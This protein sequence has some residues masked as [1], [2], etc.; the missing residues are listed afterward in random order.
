MGKSLR[1]VFAVLI[2]SVFCSAFTA[3]ADEL[4]SLL[5]QA[6]LLFYASV[7]QQEQIVPAIALFQKIGARDSS[8]LGRAQTYIGALTALRAK[9]ALWPQDKWRFANDGL[10]LMD[11][12][13][14]L[15][16]EDVEALFVHGTTCFYLPVFFG[17]SDDAQRDLRAIARLLPEQ[18]HRYDLPLVRNV[19][20]FIVQNIRLKQAEKNALQTLQEKLAPQ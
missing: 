8:L 9:H 17:R 13:L 20:N 3:R 2:A 15:A 10:K 6:R 14:K 19:I 7:E 18:Y 12:G 4:D 5:A 1:F 11:E 16:P